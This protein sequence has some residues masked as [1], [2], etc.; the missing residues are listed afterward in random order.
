[1]VSCLSGMKTSVVPASL[2]DTHCLSSGPSDSRAVLLRYVHQ[3]RTLFAAKYTQATIPFL[4]ADA[5][6]PALAAGRLLQ[7]LPQCPQGFHHGSHVATD[8]L[9]DVL[10]RPRSRAP[11]SPPSAAGEYCPGMTRL[12]ASAAGAP[13]EGHRG[14]EREER[15]TYLFQY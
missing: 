10:A 12:A 2:H 4:A 6:C 3:R 8:A 1:M 14:G 9:V 15:A 7:E 5:P 13:G 11:C